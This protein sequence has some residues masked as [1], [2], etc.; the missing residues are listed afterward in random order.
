MHV[1]V[2]LVNIYAPNFDDATL[3]NRLLGSISY[4]NSHLLILGGDLNCVIDPML[5][6]SSPRSISQSTMPK[7]FS[8]FFVQSGLV[9]PW[10]LRNPLTK[11]FSF[12]SQVHQSYSRIDN[13]FIDK[14]HSMCCF[15]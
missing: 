4:L 2:V 5:D 13:F 14:S 10:R 1:K 11:K 6:R 3:S 9:D 8:D 12:F 15:F 7:S